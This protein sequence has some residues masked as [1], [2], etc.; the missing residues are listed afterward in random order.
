MSEQVATLELPPTARSS[1]VG[2]RFVT[3]A[4]I[5]WG[6]LGLLDAA[7]LLTSEVVTNAVLHAR[8]AVT[9]T[10]LRE[11]SDSVT[12]R[13]SDGSRLRPQLR[14]HSR[15]A[16]T[17]RGVHLLD[18]LASSWGVSVDE[19]GKTVTF[20]LSGGVDPWSAYTDAGWEVD[21]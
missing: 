14:A 3:E 8:T 11:G 20:T 2:R 18:Q 10:V 5:D 9:I 21:L 16:T 7:A 6:L 15:E 13:V 1:G 12:V 19:G 17:G 4:L